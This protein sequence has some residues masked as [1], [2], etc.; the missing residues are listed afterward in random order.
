MTCQTNIANSETVKD[1]L[2]NIG[3]LTSREMLLAR[4]SIEPD[5]RV[6]EEAKPRGPSS[7]SK[8]L[9]GLGIDPDTMKVIGK[10][11]GPEVWN[12]PCI[13][14]QRPSIEGEPPEVEEAPATANSREISLQLSAGDPDGSR[15]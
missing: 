10:V 9:I 15:G 6:D 4:L 5:M 8:L 3:G 7:R 13:G 12:L 14:E 2:G 1:S 11:P